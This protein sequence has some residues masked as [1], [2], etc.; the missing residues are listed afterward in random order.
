MI[1]YLLFIKKLERG[2]LVFFLTSKDGLQKA[3]SCCIF[4][5]ASFKWRAYKNEERKKK[6]V[7]RFKR[8]SN[9][10]A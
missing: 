5:P 9:Y 8:Q 1:Q 2:G 4:A 7:C 10:N 6:N 3:K